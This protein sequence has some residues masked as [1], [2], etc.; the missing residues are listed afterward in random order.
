MAKKIQTAPE[1][2]VSPQWET[3]SLKPLSDGRVPGVDGSM[4]LYGSVPMSAIIDAKSMDKMLAGGGSLHSVYEE[5]AKLAS[6][7][8]NRAASKASYREFHLLLLNVPSYYEAPESS[9]I[10]GYLNTEFRDR[11]VQRRELLF[12]VKLRSSGTAAAGTG[13]EKLK[14]AIDSFLYTLMYTGTQ[15]SDYD[16]DHREI[17][18]IFSRAGITIPSK[19]SLRW[20]DSWWSHG[21]AKAIPT[22][23]HDDHLHYIYEMNAKREIEANYD[24]ASCRNWPEGDE[25]IQGEFAISFTALNN[26]DVGVTSVEDSVVRWAPALL[27]AG[28]RVISVRGTVEPQRVTRAQ[29]KSQKK[30]IE[31]DME[32]FAEKNRS[33]PDE[34]RQ[35]RDELAMLETSYARDEAPA[36]LF[37][38]SVIVGFDSVVEDLRKVTP[39]ALDLNPLTNL[40]A[41]AWYETMICSNV[42]ANPLKQDL[43]CTTIAYAGISNLSQVGDPPKSPKAALL[44][45]TERDGQPVYVSANAASLADGYPLMIVPGATGAGKSQVLQWLAHQWGLAGVPQYIIDPKPKSDFSAAVKASGGD[46]HSFDGFI[47]ADGPLDPIRYA[48][49]ANLQL[50]VQIASDM[51]AR[52]RPLSTELMNQMETPLANAIRYGVEQGA[53]ATGEA[54][55][56]AARDNV[57]PQNIV[58]QIVGFAQTYPMFRATFGLHPGTSSL[59]VSDG[60]TLFMAGNSQFEFPA[61]GATDITLATPGVRTSVN[62]MRQ[63]VRASVMNLS[64]RG[65][66]LHIDEEWIYELA[67]PDELVQ[68]GR[69][70]RSQN[71]LVCL[72]TQTPKGPLNLGL[73]GFISRGIIGHIPAEGEDR[74]QAEA[75]LKLF[76]STSGEILSRVVAPGE[77]SGRLNWHSLKALWERN[78]DGTRT[79]HR[80]AVFFHADLHGNIA[81]VEVQIPPSFFELASTNPEDVQRREAKAAGAFV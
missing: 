44:G 4:W 37:D 13:R 38:C 27:D 3:R 78:D 71:V 19:D 57:I 80:P 29:L 21:R 50:G 28:A 17:A 48:G 32:A 39:V 15:L 52:V 63:L 43:P 59:S 18:G 53:T 26:L 40:Q 56:I 69:L 12:G 55:I 2:P 8:I 68:L 60:I 58:D 9:P 24:V 67:A 45:F 46:V 5:L 22:L 10:R 7:G 74:S 34:Q 51:L 35:R 64:G 75:G 33:S 23:P 76:G 31:Q 54:L 14:G 66:V 65:G 77:E 79:L 25:R 36:T 61:A 62:V 16:Q 81:P 20:S 47:E 70:A 1:I 41:A 42:R 49:P 72:Y 6:A 73:G 30:R 11:I